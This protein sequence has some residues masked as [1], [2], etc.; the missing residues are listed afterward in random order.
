MSESE[1]SESKPSTLEV[2]WDFLLDFASAIGYGT[3]WFVFAAAGM[4]VPEC[5]LYV[6]FETGI[7]LY[8]WLGL[9]TYDLAWWVPVVWLVGLLGSAVFLAVFVLPWCTHRL[10]SRR[11]MAVDP[12]PPWKH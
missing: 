11:L 7:G 9:H 10:R 1:T 8:S 12:W 4:A 2:V 5:F 3:S 6:V